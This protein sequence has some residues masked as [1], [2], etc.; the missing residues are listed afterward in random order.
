MNGGQHTQQGPVYD[1]FEV[2]EELAKNQ[3]EWQDCYQTMCMQMQQ[4]LK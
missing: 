3:E 1:E 2:E 4:G